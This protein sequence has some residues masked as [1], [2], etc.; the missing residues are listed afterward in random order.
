MSA[1]LTRSP[2]GT[3]TCK[4]E[5]AKR[6]A[7]VFLA[8]ARSERAEAF[9][10]VGARREFRGGV[11]MQVKAVLPVGAVQRARVVIALGH[12]A[13]ETGILVHVC[14]AGLSSGESYRL[15]SCKNSH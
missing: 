5:L 11:D 1:L 8:A 6:F 15:Y 4:V 12:T 10:V 13:S 9:L 2:V 3:E 7:D 14:S